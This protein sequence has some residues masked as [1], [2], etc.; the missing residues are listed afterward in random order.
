[1]RLNAL[2]DLEIEL[3]PDS[4][5]KSLINK[6]QSYL[7]NLTIQ[8]VHEFKKKSMS[9]LLAKQSEIT[10]DQLTS[11]SVRQK[12]FINAILKFVVV[13]KSED[14]MILFTNP[15]N[16]L[17][18]SNDTRIIRRIIQSL[19]K[20]EKFDI[21]FKSDSISRLSRDIYDA[22]ESD[23]ELEKLNQLP[24]HLI[25]TSDNQIFNTKSRNYEDF[26]K[27]K[28]Y[29]FLYQ[30]NW[31]FFNEEMINS[32]SSK[33]KTDFM[34]YTDMTRRIING[35]CALDEHLSK[36]D[37]EKR[38]QLMQ[39][40]IA[41][42]Q[43]NSRGKYVE[44]LGEGG[45]GK[46][47]LLNAMS[48]LTGKENTLSL[49]LS[50]IGDDNRLGNIKTNTRL[51]IGHEIATDFRFSSTTTPRYKEL[52]MSDPMSINEKYML[53]RNVRFTGLGVQACNTLITFAEDNDSIRDRRF[54]IKMSSINFRNRTD[55]AIDIDS[56]MQQELF[57]S[58]YATYIFNE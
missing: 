9:R 45:N 33:D 38:I 48:S 54:P 5:D 57:R 28:H 11:I 17:L 4:W 26:N 35:W 14:D 21:V 2:S 36:I 46:S 1:M 43:G 40:Q 51:I 15:T 7:K 53:P 13:K 25:L 37:E 27:F 32:L 24:N 55:L 49:N 34:L 39:I 22:L 56:Y 20:Y 42:I 31:K 12:D 50:Q 10:P 6:S 41:A 58:A 23:D 16:S 29:D 19:N 44:L 3:L 18:L 52:A 30:C 47:S 8:F